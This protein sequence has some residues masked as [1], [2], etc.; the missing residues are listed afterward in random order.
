ISCFTCIFGQMMMQLSPPRLCEQ[1]L[2]KRRS[3][4]RTH[5][6]CDAIGV[7]GTQ[8]LAKLSSVF[9]GYF[10]VIEAPPRGKLQRSIDIW[11]LASGFSFVRV[12]PKCKMEV[13]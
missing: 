12:T 8:N 3:R 13:S 6:D 4:R 10:A 9:W 2:R 1:H 7:R 11:L 5:T